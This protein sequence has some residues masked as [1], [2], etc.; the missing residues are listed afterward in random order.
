MA[1]DIVEKLS[2][3]IPIDTWLEQFSLE[4]KNLEIRGES[5]KVLSLIDTLGKNSNFPMYALNRPSPVIK[6]TDETVS[7]LKLKAEVAHA[8]MW[9]YAA[10]EI[11]GLGIINRAVVG[12]DF[13]TD[14]AA[15]AMER[16]TQ[17]KNWIQ[18]IQQLSRFRQIANATPEMMKEYERVQQQGL[19]KLFYPSVMTYAQVAME[20]QTYLSDVIARNN[21]VLIS[22]E[23]VDE[24][25]ARS[26]NETDEAAKTPF[27][28]PL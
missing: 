15:D 19:D 18:V 20:L 3:S 28:N 11:A 8:S 25:Q 4:G 6:K 27:I 22:S 17:P 13:S 23:V 2:V 9:L 21:G 26:Q 1:L 14:F 24:Q 10:S 5:A 12:D 16:T 7:I